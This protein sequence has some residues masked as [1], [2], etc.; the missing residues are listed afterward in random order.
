M[1]VLITSCAGRPDSELAVSTPVVSSPTPALARDLSLYLANSRRTGEYAAV[2]PDRIPT[3]NWTYTTTLSY[4][5]LVSSVAVATGVI[6][7]ITSE[8]YIHQ[9]DAKT[10]KEQW[11]DRAHLA[12]AAIADGV[13]YYGWKSAL[14]AVDTKTQR[15]LWSFPT[16]NDIQSSPAI[17]NGCIYFG[18]NDGYLYAVDEKTGQLVWKFHAGDQVTGD[19]AVSGDLVYIAG[20]T[21]LVTPGVD[22]IGSREQIYAVDGAT[23]AQRW[24]F[25]ATSS[26]HNPVVANGIVYCVGFDSNAVYALEAMSGQQIWTYTPSDRVTYD[27]V[28][29]IANG[30]LYITGMGHTLHAVDL[31]TRQERWTITTATDITPPSIAQGVLY[32][33]SDDKYLHAV[34]ALSGH[35]NWRIPT[36]SVVGG[37]PV[38]ADGTIYIVGSHNVYAIR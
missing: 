13:V 16:G 12:T 4:D 2:G 8:G 34:D 18:S 25:P 28:P 38:I 17:A 19:P 10:G 14:Y 9:L 11:Q 30:I 32:F 24:A 1:A 33:G 37:P 22:V 23:G 5:E 15:R 7:F 36:A 3:V 20:S 26:V 21:L 31:Q 27:A 35:E 6:S 29:V